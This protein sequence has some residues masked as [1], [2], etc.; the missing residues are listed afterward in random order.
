MKWAGELKGGNNEV[1]KKATSYKRSP[2]NNVRVS[3]CYFLDSGIVMD[4]YLQIIATS[5][6]VATL[7]V[8]LALLLQSRKLRRRDELVT[9]LKAENE[10]LLPYAKIRDAESEAGH[11]LRTARD[12]AA[13]IAQELEQ[14]RLTAEAA[15][16][17]SRADAKVIMEE[18][19]AEASRLKDAAS[20]AYSEAIATGKSE[21]LEL[22][23]NAKTQADDIVEAARRRAAHLIAEAEQKAEETAGQALKALHEAE[24]LDGLVKALKN[25]IEGYGDEYLIPGITLLDQIAED[26]DYSSASQDYKLVKEQVKRMTKNGQAAICDYVEFNRRITAINFVTDAFNGKVE[27]TLARLRHDNYGKLR[28]EILDAFALVNVNGQAFRSA[29]ITKEYLDLRLEELRLGVVLHEMKLADVAEQ[30]RI[31]DQIR[32]E[33]RAQREFERALRDA[34]KEEESLRKALEKVRGSYEAAGEEQKQKYENQLR[35]ME[36]R[37]AE[38][39]AKSQRALS[40]AQQ[41][42]SGHVYVISNIGS[43]GEDVLKIGMTRR[44][45]PLDRI[46]ELGD[47]SVPFEFDVHAMIFSEDAPSLERDLH[48]RFALCQVNKI[49]SRK[50][51]FRIRLSELRQVVEA[52]RLG[53]IHW[54]MMAEA[55][56]FHETLALEQ[57]LSNPAERQA[58]LSQ[59]GALFDMAEVDEEEDEGELVA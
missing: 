32:E 43:F 36:E 24:Q 48:K 34:A 5:F 21:A 58:W 13:Q 47:A 29:R 40:M 14:R 54:T 30:K 35:E 50:E 28:Q 49:N 27:T 45:E 10:S 26:Y 3:T 55:R 1:S 8:G 57:R 38:A 56:Q 16:D 23:T 39:Q 59:Q 4:I 19:Q 6:G 7:V 11:I 2:L 20:T 33:Q 53:D 9:S 41:T 44:L 42:K 12:Q 25:R 17:A 46:R 18:A 37:L 31:K 51:F 52:R 22:T 15:V